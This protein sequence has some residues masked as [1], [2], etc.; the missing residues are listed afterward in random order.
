MLH[1]IGGEDARASA[2]PDDIAGRLD[3]L[4]VKPPAEASRSI[5]VR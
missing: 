3:A 4:R 5:S 1:V 2:F